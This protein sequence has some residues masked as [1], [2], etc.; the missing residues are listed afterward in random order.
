MFYCDAEL[1]LMDIQSKER[2]IKLVIQM[3][4]LS[5]IIFHAFHDVGTLLHSLITRNEV[6]IYNAKTLQKEYGPYK[7]KKLNSSELLEY[8]TEIKLSSKCKYLFTK[9]NQ[10]KSE[11]LMHET[12]RPIDNFEYENSFYDRFCGEDKILGTNYEEK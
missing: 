11:F 2:F 8:V 5:L 10:H 1:N 7:L 4:V 3:K 9:H 6:I 12:G